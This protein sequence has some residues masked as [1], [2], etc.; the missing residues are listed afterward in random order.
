MVAVH[1][2]VE[3]HSRAG[4]QS[5]HL[6][7]LLDAERHHHSGHVFPDRP[8]RDED[9]PRGTIDGDDDAVHRERLGGQQH[10]QQVKHV[11]RL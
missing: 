11:G 9:R 1:H 6:A 7:R 4:I 8:V 2:E 3:A 10:R 5:L